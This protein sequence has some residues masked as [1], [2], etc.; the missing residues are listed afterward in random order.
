MA[1]TQL[2]RVLLGAAAALA[3]TLTAAAV[4][5]ADGWGIEHEKVTRVDAKVVDLLCEITGKCAPDCGGGKHQLGLLLDDGRL[6]PV[7]KNF[8]PFAGAVV[9]LHSF[10][11][12]RITADGL[13]IENPK[14]PLF[15]LQFK[16]LAPDGEWS[17]A[18][19]FGK[20]WSKAN[21]GANA[22][23]WFRK[24]PRIAEEIKANGVFGIPGLKPE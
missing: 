2:T 7:A 23:E 6:I 15:A 9:D 11:G 14:M 17:R 8:E 20:E 22:D 24:D 4:Q 1:R 18:N 13:L 3:F 10:C 16:R 12:K 5:A 21:G 19:W